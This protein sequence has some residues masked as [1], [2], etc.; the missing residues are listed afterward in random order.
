MNCHPL[1]GDIFEIVLG[2]FSLF[3]GIALKPFC[4][5]RFVDGS[6]MRF[7]IKFVHD[8]KEITLWLNPEAW[9][10]WLSRHLQRFLVP[11]APMFYT[12][13]VS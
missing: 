11:A 10:F 2:D 6:D 7:E 8:L 13:P 12:H 1:L 5:V 4:G 9:V 3:H